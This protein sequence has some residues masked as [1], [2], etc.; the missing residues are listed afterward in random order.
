MYETNYE[1]IYNENITETKKPLLLVNIINN[2]LNISS[3]NKL[4]IL[5][6]INWSK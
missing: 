2:Y 4:R 6:I 3:V 1:L 5:L